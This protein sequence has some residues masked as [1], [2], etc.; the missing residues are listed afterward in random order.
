MSIQENKQLVMRGYEQFQNRDIQGLMDN[1]AEDYCGGR[2]CF[3]ADGVRSATERNG[4]TAL[5]G[6]L[7]K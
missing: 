2:S 6:V 4:G 7:K 3:H 5:I 1:F